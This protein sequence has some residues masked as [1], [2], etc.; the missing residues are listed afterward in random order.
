MIRFKRTKQ[1]VNLLSYDI[2]FRAKLEGMDKWVNIEEE[3]INHTYNTSSMISA[4]IG[5]TPSGFDGKKAKDIL[6]LVREAIKKLK[7]EPEV[8]RLYEPENKWGTLEST[9]KFLIKIEAMCAEY[10]ET[11]VDV[12]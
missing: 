6:P 2:Y 9:L 8:Y 10:P 3:S 1:E 5:I 12:M 11:I 7:E 4:A